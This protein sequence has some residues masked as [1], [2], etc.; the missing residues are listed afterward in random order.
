MRATAFF[1]HWWGGHEQV[2]TAISS[3]E[4][5]ADRRSVIY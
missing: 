3:G 5:D 2:G 1:W 4:E